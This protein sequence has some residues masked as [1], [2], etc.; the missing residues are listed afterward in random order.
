MSVFFLSKR[1]ACDVLTFLDSIDSPKE[2]SETITVILKL[3]SSSPL[4]G[5]RLG[6]YDN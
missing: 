5:N 1:N 3:E 2:F 6:R 4:I